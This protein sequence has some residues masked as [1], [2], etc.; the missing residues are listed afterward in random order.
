M[1]G[2]PIGNFDDLKM[3]Q[4]I[5]CNLYQLTPNQAQ[6]DKDEM[7]QKRK[8]FHS[9]NAHSEHQGIQNIL[10]NKSRLQEQNL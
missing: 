2:S 1:M 9:R 3:T 10:F 4:E 6:M 5:E 7:F 8:S